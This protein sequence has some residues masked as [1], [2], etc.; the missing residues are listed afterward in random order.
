MGDALDVEV[1]AINIATLYSECLSDN[2]SDVPQLY[3]CYIAYIDATLH[4]KQMA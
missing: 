2:F 3:K 4:T 1:K